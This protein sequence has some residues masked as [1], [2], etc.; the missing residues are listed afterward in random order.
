[1]KLNKIYYRAEENMKKAIR[2]IVLLI[3]AGILSFAVHEARADYDGVATRINALSTKFPDG[4]YWNHYKEN[5][6]DKEREIC[7]YID[8]KP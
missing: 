8:I 5:E 2:I 7:S 6:K 3:L 1:M 4:K